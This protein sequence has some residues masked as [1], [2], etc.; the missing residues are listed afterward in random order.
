MCNCCDN[1]VQPE[2]AGL[3]GWKVKAEYLGTEKEQKVRL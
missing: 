2:V 1:K 3:C